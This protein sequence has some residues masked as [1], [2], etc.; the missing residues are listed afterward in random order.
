MK[1]VFSALL[2]LFFCSLS[3]AQESEGFIELGGGFSLIEAP[4][5][6]GSDQSNFFVLPFPYLVYESKKVSMNREGLNRHLFKGENWDLDMSFAG[7]LPVQSDDNRAR[8]GMDDLDWLTQAG[9][10][11]NYYFLR[12]KTSLFK[13][14]F[15]LHYGLVTDFT[16]L[17]YAGWELAPNFRYEKLFESSEAQYRFIGSIS[18]YYGSERFNQL[19]YGVAPELATANRPEYFA[20][21][22]LAGYQ[23]M[24]GLT[25][26][27]DKFWMG[28][29]ARFRTVQGAVF[30]DSPLVKQ[31]ENFYVGLAFAWIIHRWELY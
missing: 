6:A 31:N 27:K 9:P 11:F 15:P 26:R 22:G 3:K 19:Y 30:E 17:D 12:D 7:R 14:Q 21:H 23:L 1:S 16:Y 10:A 25:R 29:F 28:A 2:M 18:S 13:F 5:Y 4:H 20:E 24:L 8:E